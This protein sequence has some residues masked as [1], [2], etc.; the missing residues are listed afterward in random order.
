MNSN[1]FDFVKS[2]F[3]NCE[4]DVPLSLDTGVIEGKIMAKTK[5][6]KIKFKKKHGFIKNITAVAA[7]FIL[8]IGVAFAVNS[9][10]FDKNRVAGFHNYEELNAK[11]ST[12]EKIPT[13]SEMGGGFFCTKLYITEDG[14]ENPYTVKYYNGHLFYAYYNSNDS[15]NRNKVY[16]FNAN[17]EDSNLI[18][19][20]DDFN[21]DDF[22]IQD[23]FAQDKRLI[24]N[25]TSEESV[26][27]KIYDIS[28]CADPILISQFKQEGKYSSSNVIGNKLFVFTSHIDSNNL[29]YIEDNGERKTVSYEDIVC[30]ENATVAQYAV[31]NSID[32]EKGTQAGDL[33]AV[34]GGSSKVHCTKDYIYINEYI[35]GE[36]YG[37]PEREVSCAMKMN[38]ENGKIVYATEEEIKQYSKVFVDIGRGDGYESILYPIGDYFISIGDNLSEPEDEI[39]LFDKN[40]NEIDSIIL[41]NSSVLT[42]YG[43]LASDEDNN[44]F[45]LPAY[46]A[47]EVKR[48]YGVLTFA[49]ENNKIVIKDKFMNDD[50][51]AM[52]QG[53]CIFAG[54]YLYSFNIND[55]A[56][57]SEKVKI[58]AY[59][60]E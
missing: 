11:L 25:L 12:L 44:T 37:E 58:F 52:Y 3:D 14:A 60:Y 39:I 24:V 31:I 36:I 28:N 55:F 49:I 18:A 34:L 23:L 8:I 30:F 41:D 20:I 19:L 56:E 35:E 43:T 10:Y 42:M 32:I 4:L 53:M 2:K 45:A 22:E 17:G 5:H 59:K 40:L 6:K 16:I 46:F 38:V 21:L 9:G 29:P 1:D 27:T 15:N 48:N 51:N 50:E 33:K 54:D 13:L 57:D 47:D 26:I 7:C